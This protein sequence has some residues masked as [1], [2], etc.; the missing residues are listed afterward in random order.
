GAVCE[1][2]SGS[3]AAPPSPKLYVAEPAR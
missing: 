2:A 1:V 3:I